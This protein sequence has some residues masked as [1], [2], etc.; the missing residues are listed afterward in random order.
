MRGPE[1]KI[2]DECVVIAREE[3]YV[4]LKVKFSGRVGLPDRLLSCSIPRRPSYPPV[5]ILVEFKRVGGRTSTA[6]ELVH[7]ELRQE[8]M[9]I[10][11]IDS[12]ETFRSRLHALKRKLARLSS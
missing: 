2:E 7:R 8:G 12:V 11:L 9:T 1:A 5:F 10:W 6:Q 3:G 4:L